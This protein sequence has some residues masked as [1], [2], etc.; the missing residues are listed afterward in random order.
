MN[1]IEAFL[2]THFRPMWSFVMS[3]APL[4]RQ[5]N[6]FLINRGALR[7][8]TRPHRLSSMAL[9]G[10]IS[11]TIAGYTSWE[12]LQDR[13]WFSRH[14]P[15]AQLIN[16][17]EPNK[18]KELY[19][20]NE[21]GPHIS[22]YSTVLFLS[23]AQW[24][25][26]GFLM[27]TREDRRKTDTSH[28]IDFNALYGLNRKQTQAVR[29]MSDTAGKKGRL[30]CETNDKGDVYAPRYFD[31]TGVVK[32]EFE[33]LRPPLG[34]DDFLKSRKPEEAKQIQ[35]TIFAFAGERAN[36]TPYTA[37]LNILFLREHNRIAGLLEAAHTDWD[38]E[39]VFQTARNINTVL[40]IKIVIEEYINHIAPYHFRFSADPSV[41]WHAKWNKPNWIPIEFN[42]LYRWHSLTPSHFDINGSTFPGEDIVYNNAHLIE[43]GLA[44][45]MVSASDQPSWE[46]GLQNTPEFLLDVEI[47]SAMQGRRNEMA[48]YND[49]RELFGFPRVTRFEQITGNPYRLQTL[50]SLYDKV[51]DIEFFVGLFAEDVRPSSA[52]P[53]LIGRMVGL[54]AF[55]QAL[56]NPLLSEHVFNE[57]TFSAEGMKIIEETSKLQDILNR[58][59]QDGRGNYRVTMTYGD[60]K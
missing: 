59:T 33:V 13:D 45:L 41:C 38:D 56:T 27:T 47:A 60:Y 34:L 26:D 55:T 43:N 37:M 30:K 4:R 25:T 5:V 10:D 32:E 49:Y 24:F 7:A 35:K 42:L 14:L 44:T 16:L 19:T 12:S 8:P 54:D 6:R 52:V 11:N 15:P 39:R 18:L 21:E 51:D 40:L 20:V 1:K 50:K 31:E 46:M 29:L 58:N 48:A 28:H 17:P 9:K 36:T 57:K 23:F 3:I 2:L 53:P 22:D